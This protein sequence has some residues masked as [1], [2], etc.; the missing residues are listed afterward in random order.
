MHDVSGNVGNRCALPIGC[1]A[2]T[3]GVP[4]EVCVVKL[5]NGREEDSY[6][7]YLFCQP[8][9][10]A[11]RRAQGKLGGSAGL[12]AYFTKQITA[13]CCVCFSLVTV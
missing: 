8:I 6:L 5:T 10:C 11:E 7:G 3:G 1:K 9:H 2:S 12:N 13:S 4:V